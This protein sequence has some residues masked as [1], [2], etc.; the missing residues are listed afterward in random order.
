MRGFDGPIQTGRVVRRDPVLRLFRKSIDFTI[1]LEGR[2]TIVHAFIGI[3]I[4]ETVPDVVRFHYSGDPSKRVVLFQYEENMLGI[5]L[6][7]WGL[8]AALWAMTRLPYF[9][10]SL[11]WP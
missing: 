3:K 4:A 9:R 10:K 2:E 6:L 5:V 8:A 7:F 11:S 1:Q